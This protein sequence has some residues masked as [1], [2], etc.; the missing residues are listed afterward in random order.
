MSFEVSWSLAAEA[1]L[2]RIPSWRDAATV[3]QAVYQLAATGEGD[4]RRRGTSRTEFA[5]YVGSHCVWLSFDRAA[6]KIAVGMI[7]AA[8]R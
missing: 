1:A 6:R 5:L 7:F 2:R 8:H 3:S 4:L